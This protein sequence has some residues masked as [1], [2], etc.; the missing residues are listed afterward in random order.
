MSLYLEKS[1]RLLEASEINGYNFEMHTYL[2]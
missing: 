2:R 1:D